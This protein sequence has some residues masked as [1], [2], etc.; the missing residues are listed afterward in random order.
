MSNI[1]QTVNVDKNLKTLKRAVHASDLDQLLS[2]TG[3]YTFFAPSDMAFEKLH[4]GTFDDLMLP[5]NKVALTAL[6]NNHILDSKV[7]Y[8]QL[9]DG[10]S[11]TTLGGKELVV[12]IKSGDVS[13]GDVHLQPRDARISNGSLFV[14]NTVLQ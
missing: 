12:T 11:F 4:A 10:D 5:E 7:L 14:I 1:T 9:K 8:N 6:L 2:S 3:P 13:I